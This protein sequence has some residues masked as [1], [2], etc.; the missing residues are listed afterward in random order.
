VACPQIA[1]TTPEARQFAI[2]RV[3]AA[4]ARD[5]H[6]RI[7]SRAAIL[8]KA[9]DSWQQHQCRQGQPDSATNLCDGLEGSIEALIKQLLA[10]GLQPPAELAR[11]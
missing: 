11:S 4:E 7:A 3:W 1:R 5:R 6:Q 2:W 9:L 10:D 8:A